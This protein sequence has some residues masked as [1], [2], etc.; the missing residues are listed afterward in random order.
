ME[1]TKKEY[2]MR[3]ESKIH[4]KGRMVALNKAHP[5]VGGIEEYRP[6]IVMSPVVKFLEGYIVGALR[7]YA[8]SRLSREQFGFVPGLSI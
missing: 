7:L 6:I 3:E 4:L 5:K 8:K 2:W 1:L